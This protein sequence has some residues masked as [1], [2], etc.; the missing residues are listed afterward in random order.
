ERDQIDGPVVLLE[1]GQRSWFNGLREA[2]AIE[3]EDRGLV[4][5]HPPF[6]WMGI[7]HDRLADRDTV[8]SGLVLVV[9]EVVTGD[10]AAQVDVPGRVI[11]EVAPDRPFD[12]EALDELVDQATTGETVEISTDAQ[13]AIDRMS[14]DRSELFRASLSFLPAHADEALIDRETLEF[15]HDHPLDAPRLDPDLVDRVLDSLPSAEQ[16]RL[17]VFLLERDEIRDF[18]RPGGEL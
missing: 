13:R 10:V 17:R 4:V 11:A 1:R 12:Q 16:P 14:S 2:L 9:D 8:R 6:L 3:L 15:L 7:H 18:A 5:Q